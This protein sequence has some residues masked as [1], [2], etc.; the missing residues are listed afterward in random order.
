MARVDGIVKLRK[1]TGLPF[2]L[3][4]EAFDKYGGVICI[5]LEHFRVTNLPGE[6]WT[7]I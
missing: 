3:C 4:K 1:L 6:M 2:K 7:R 5:N